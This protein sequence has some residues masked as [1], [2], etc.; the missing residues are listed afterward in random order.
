MADTGKGSRGGAPRTRLTRIGRDR[1]L[2]G[3]F[4]NPPVVH[5][6]TVLFPDTETYATGN[7][8]WRYGRRG[9][10][11]TAALQNAITELHNAAGT[12]LCPSGL[13]AAAT[14]LT[15][16]LSAGDRV[17]IVDTVYDPVRQLA[18]DLLAQQGVET[19]YFD[20]AIGDGIERLFDDRTRVVYA[21]APGSLTLEMMDVDAVTAVAQ[22]HGAVTIFDN[23][24]ATP[25]YY[26]PLDHGVDVVVETGSKYIG[27]H[28][29]VMIGV[30]AAN[31]AAWKRLEKTHGLLGLHVGPDDVFLALRGLRSLNVRLQAHQE[32]AMEIATWL[33]KRDEVARVIY[34][35]LPDDPGHALWRRDM[36]G[37]ASLLAMTFHGWSM[38]RA[39]AFVDALQLFGLGASWGGYESLVVVMDPDRYRSA[40]TWTEGPLVRLYIGLEDPADLIADLEAAFA[41]AA[42]A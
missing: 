2:T 10:P 23:T 33:T 35:P 39:R 16:Y 21:E 30:A 24:W 25:L 13:S 17:L 1:D 18:D 38:A 27:G 5:A 31:E 29:D 32:S 12:V 20:P 22:R 14:A 34:P 42:G 9:T 40:T 36:N 11:T 4:V 26:R 6:T 3:P 15:A 37:G 7:Q 28:S 41:A 8:R 19:V